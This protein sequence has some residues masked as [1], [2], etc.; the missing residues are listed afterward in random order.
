VKL[1]PW[2]GSPFDQAEPEDGPQLIRMPGGA[3]VDRQWVEAE[4]VRCA[5]REAALRARAEEREAAVE[6]LDVERAA[7]REE[8]KR[9]VLAHLRDAGIIP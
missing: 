3:L 4:R 2:Q 9:D 5:E 7:Q 1:F 6:A 8:L